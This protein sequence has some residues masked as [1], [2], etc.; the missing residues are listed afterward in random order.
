MPSAWRALLALWRR[1]GPA[2]L[3]AAEDPHAELLAL[4]WGP[5]FD[6]THAAHW[7]GQA[8][9]GAGGASRSRFALAQAASLFD[10][11]P[12]TQQQRLR[13]LILAHHAHS[14]QAVPWRTM[15][16]GPHPA[17]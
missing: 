9:L 2:L 14:P 17:H 3:P 12:A 15:P 6:R 13:R 4:V 1:H 16:H 11:M 5:R 8:G 7:L 10:Q